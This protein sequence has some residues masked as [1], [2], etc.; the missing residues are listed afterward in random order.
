MHVLCKYKFHY[1]SSYKRKICKLQFFLGNW[2]TRKAG[3]R[4]GTG[5]WKRLSEAS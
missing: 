2:K 5:N 4:M 3:A 1:M